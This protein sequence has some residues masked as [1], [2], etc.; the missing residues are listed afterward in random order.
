MKNAFTILAAL[1]ALAFVSADAA[2]RTPKSEIR[3]TFME[4][5]NGDY[6]LFIFGSD[7][8]LVCEEKDIRIVQQGDAVNPV[9]LEC[10]HE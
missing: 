1:L 10:K 8:I 2:P 7:H 4:Q 3:V 9:V 5:E 6:R